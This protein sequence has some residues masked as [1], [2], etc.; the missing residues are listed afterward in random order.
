MQYWSKEVC[1]KVNSDIRKTLLGKPQRNHHYIISPVKLGEEVMIKV[2][3]LGVTVPSQVAYG[4]SRMEIEVEIEEGG[5][6]FQAVE[7]TK[8]MLAE[9][10]SGGDYDQF[11]KALE[12]QNYPHKTEE[13][14]DIK[15]ELRALENELNDL[16]SQRQQKQAEARELL[17][18]L[19]KY[20][21]IDRLKLAPMQ[22]GDFW[23][24]LTAVVQEVFSEDGSTAIGG[25]AGDG[26]S[27]I[28]SN[29]DK[30]QEF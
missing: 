19:E 9:L 30:Y 23:G 17:R 13:I 12:C 11:V 26:D 28:D 18:S 4:S 10:I 7:R 27:D 21:I 3:R 29:I 8:K 24:G 15:D 5:S 6:V 1:Q 14:Q 16:K 20:V 25:N 2:V 22:P